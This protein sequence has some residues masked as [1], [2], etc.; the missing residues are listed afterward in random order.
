MV[1][2][3]GTPPPHLPIPSLLPTRGNSYRGRGKKMFSFQIRFEVL[4]IVYNWVLLT[5]NLRLCLQSKGLLDFCLPEK[6]EELRD[7]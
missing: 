3:K 1:Q 7:F 4:I 6:L 5:M 2:G